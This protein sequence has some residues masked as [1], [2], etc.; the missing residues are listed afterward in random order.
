MENQL[1]E[2]LKDKMGK[3]IK[4]VRLVKDLLLH[5]MIKQSMKKKSN[6]Y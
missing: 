3:L 2:R 6:Y 4:K 1:V 5:N